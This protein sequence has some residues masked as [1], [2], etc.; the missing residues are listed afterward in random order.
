MKENVADEQLLCKLG[1]KIEKNDIN[2]VLYSFK[3]YFR[4]Y[5]D[6]KILSSKDIYQKIKYILNNS[7]F[8]MHFFKREFKIYD[9]NKKEIDIIVKDLN[10]LIQLKDNIKLNNE[11]L[12]DAYI[13][14]ENRKIELKEK[15]EKII[16]FVKYIEQLQNINR[17]FSK[18]ENKGCPFLI[19]IIITTSKGEISF[20]LVNE[21]IKYN[22]LIFKLKQFCNTIIEYKFKL[23]KENEYFRYIYD[24]LLYRLYKRVWLNDKDISS[25]IRFITN[26]DSIKDNVPFYESRFNDLFIEYKN[27][28]LAIEEKFEIISKYIEYIFTINNTSLKKLY[29]QI[30]VK[31]S[32]NLSGIYKC[33]IEKYN[34]NLFI[35]KIF[36]KLTGRFPIAQNILLTN[37]E[38]STGEIY[39]FLYRSIKCR[40][41]TLFVISIND[42]FHAQKVNTMTS[43]MNK[44]I[45]DMKAENIIKEMKDLK[46]CILFIIQKNFM[47]ADFQ[48]IY[49]LPEYLKGDENKLEYNFILDNSIDSNDSLVYEIYNSVKV[50]TSDCCGLGKSYSIKKE[51]KERGEDYKYFGIGDVITKEEL[52]KKFKK[53]L[54]NEIKGKNHVGIHLDLFYTRDIILMEEF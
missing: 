49:D 9:D 4:N 34:M 33:N 3:S 47:K 40:F 1:E 13:M 44:I 51:I 32:E 38:T 22:E 53:F 27:Y 7:K 23:Y 25:Y 24:K 10:E 42:D 52:F 16:K 48:E 12:P 26:G 15:K 45:R 39:S 28:K 18:L 30:K 31:E 21:P 14:N 6:I 35:I 36:L 54:K 17:Y 41:N 2:Q 29:N 37:N 20:E 5:A 46:P 8:K 43:L 11:E 19:N 50:F